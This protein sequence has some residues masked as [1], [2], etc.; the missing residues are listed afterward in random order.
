MEQTPKDQV[1]E[2]KEND[3]SI[4]EV[5]DVVSEKKPIGKLKFNK[6]KKEA[7]PEVPLGE[8]R[9]HKHII[10]ADLADFENFC[11]E[12]KTTKG[13]K[14]LLSSVDGL[15]TYSFIVFEYSI[16][17]TT[18]Y[19]KY[20]MH[21]LN[22]YMENVELIWSKGLFLKNIGCSLWSDELDTTYG[23]YKKEKASKIL[24]LSDEKA[25]ELP[26]KVYFMYKKLQK[27]YNE[28]ILRID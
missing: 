4:E 18:K 24:S 11:E 7:N 13:F 21:P 26:I 23:R 20:E 1:P 14:F 6:T 27:M 17:I 15:V 19:A 10:C 25:R 3:L 9:G 16:A 8:L 2:T 22:T 28:D 5:E 12:M